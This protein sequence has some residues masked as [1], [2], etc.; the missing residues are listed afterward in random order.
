MQNTLRMLN[1][2]DDAFFTELLAGQLRRAGFDLRFKR[3]ETP[4]EMS[5]A[6]EAAP[7][8]VILSDHDLPRFDGFSALSLLKSKGFDIPF[9]L[10]SGALKEE[11]AVEAMRLG[12]QDYFVKGNL[13]RLVPSIERELQQARLRRRLQK[14]E[15]QIASLV[16]VDALTGLPNR[17]RFILNLEDA[18]RRGEASHRPFSVLILDLDNFRAVNDT[19]G[20]SLGDV[21]LR[22]VGMRLERALSASNAI[23]RIGGDEFGLILPMA[24]EGHATRMAEAVFKALEAP[25]VVQ[26][27]PVSI[28]PSIGISIFPLHG[29]SAEALLQRSDIA[30]YEA[31]RRGCV[32]LTYDER[33][34]KYSPEQLSLMGELRPAIRKGELALF[35]QPKMDLKT[36]RIAALEAL[37]RWRHPRRGTLGPSAFLLPAEQTGLIVPLTEWV[38]QEALQ[39]SRRFCCKGLSLRMAVNVSARNLNRQLVDQLGE[40][41][42]AGDFVPSELVLELTE[43]SIMNDEDSV[44]QVLSEIREMGIGLAID[45]FGTGYSSL[46]YLKSLAVDILKIDQ[47]FVRNMASSPRDRTLT[48]TIIALAHN[49]G[50]SV[51]AEGVE[52]AESLKLLRADGCDMAQGYF[53]APPMPAED[54]EVWLEQSGPKR[55]WPVKD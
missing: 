48:Q 34:D 47:S 33:H 45:D 30:M 6:L 53:I 10:V 46:A 39:Q 32:A 54:L 7:W 17:A 22:E 55:A 23:A 28:E 25:F 24:E 40:A 26:N 9:F 50:L 19:L 12:A 5:E 38:L 51:V 18:I 3:V 15:R 27:I 4:E 20:H 21:L 8:D 2:E 36:G 11:L 43:S 41:L 1:I 42:Q 13:K 29:R 14:K 49:L 44:R 37:I 16:Y 31:K 52:D 35:Y